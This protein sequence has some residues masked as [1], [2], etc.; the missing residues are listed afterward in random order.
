MTSP[1]SAPPTAIRPPTSCEKALKELLAQNPKGMILDLRNNGG[2]YL[3]TAIEVVSQFIPKGVV[4]Y[5]V[6]GNGTERHL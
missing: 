6:Y 5:E 2:G 4:M 3:N 1:T